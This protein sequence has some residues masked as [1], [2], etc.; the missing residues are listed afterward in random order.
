VLTGNVIVDGGTTVDVTAKGMTAETTTIGGTTAAKGAVTVD[1]TTGTANGNSIGAVTVTGGT[2]ISVTQTA[3]NAAK[4]GVDTTGGDVTITGNADTTAVTSIQSD[5]ATGLTATATAAGKVGFTTGDVDIADANAGSATKAGTIATVTLTGFTGAKGDAAT[6]DSGA[7]TTL[8]L[9]G[10]GADDLDVTAGA[11]TTAVVDTLA[12]NLNGF[13]HTASAGGRAIVIDA[14]YKTIN[15]DSSGTKSTVGEIS[16]AGAKTLNVTGDAAATFTASTVTALKTVTVT[17][18]AGF[19]MDDISATTT[20]TGGAG[21]DGVTLANA[22]ETTIDMGAGDDTVTYGGATSTTA[23][24]VGA[25]KG[26]DGKDTIVMTTAQADGADATAAFNTAFTGFEVLKISNELDANDT[27]DV[28]GLNGVSEVVLADGGNTVAT[29]IIDKIASGGTVETQASGSAG[30]TVQVNNAALNAADVLN[31]KLTNSTNASD[32]FLNV[33]AANVETINITTNDT[34]TGNNAAATVD[35]LNL[36]ATAAKTITVTGNNGL[37]ID[38]TGN[39][40]MTSF[41]ASGVVGDSAA[42][43]DTAALLKVQATSAN[44]TTTATVT[45]KGGAGDDALTG[46]AAKDTIIG[47]AGADTI[48]GELGQ[49]TLTGG[50]GKDVF[51]FMTKAGTSSD[52]TTAAADTI[53]DFTMSSSAAAGDSLSLDADQAGADESVDIVANVTSTAGSAAGVTAAVKSG[54]LTL[55]GAGA[56]GVDTIAEWLAE[57]GNVAGNNGDVVAFEFSGDTY[58]F[59]NNAANDLLIEL[60]GVTG[61]T[62]LLEAAAATTTDATTILYTDV[63]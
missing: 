53:T 44:T 41:D 38:L 18:T 46:N 34:G 58:V 21:K 49:D 43:V 47:N 54:I 23:G 35:V 22:M 3:G 63:A 45:M 24:K 8:N 32:N 40:A 12:L 29:S 59:V 31:L 57:A 14:D 42:T 37:N 33:V 2:T 60:D 7:L 36:D 5:T 16:I 11:L 30:F 4:T 27:I 55:S 20:F 62:A 52:S 9:S 1:L 39:T 48:S 13:T 28:V 15:L 6:V 17:N 19:V 51:K 50:A 61:A 25:V 10:T 26:G 56:S